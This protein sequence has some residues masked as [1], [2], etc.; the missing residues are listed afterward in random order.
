[1]LQDEG[2]KRGTGQEPEPAARVRVLGRFSGASCINSPKRSTAAFSYLQLHPNR[3]CTAALV[4][5]LVEAS[6]GR[7]LTLEA[8]TPN[9][10]GAR[11]R[12]RA[13]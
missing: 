5:T 13:G 10:A 7:A 4:K 9:H 6:R 12:R 11:F 3:R 1:M 8:R 2:L